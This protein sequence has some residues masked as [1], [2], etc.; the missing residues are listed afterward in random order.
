MPGG[1]PVTQEG[2][3]LGLATGAERDDGLD[4]PDLCSVDADRELRVTLVRTLADLQHQGVR[5]GADGA[6]AVPTMK[7]PVPLP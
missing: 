2:E 7:S 4:P 6:A 1:A 3:R 5:S